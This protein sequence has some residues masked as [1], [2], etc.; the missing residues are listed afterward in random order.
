MTVTLTAVLTPNRVFK[1]TYD[2][3]LVSD[4]V[5]GRMQ[6]AGREYTIETNV[7]GW[8]GSLDT[9]SGDVEEA[10]RPHAT[11]LARDLGLG[12]LHGGRIRLVT[13]HVA[14]LEFDFDTAPVKP[15]VNPYGQIVPGQ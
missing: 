6:A 9:L 1:D 15:V 12:G 13:A 14:I 2:S 4:R 11:R 8:N 3:L 5:T 10:I 7:V